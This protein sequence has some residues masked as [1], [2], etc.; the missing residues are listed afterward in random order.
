MASYESCA[1][2]QNYIDPDL[3]NWEHAY[4]GESLSQLIEVKRKYD[5]SDL[6]RFTQSIPTSQP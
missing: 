4:Y 5:R 3:E 6:F 1:A 2:Y